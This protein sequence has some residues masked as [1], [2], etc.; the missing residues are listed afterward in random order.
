M[1]DVA[2]LMKVIFDIKKV[3]KLYTNC[4]DENEIAYLAESEFLIKLINDKLCT[5][6]D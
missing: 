6:P 2:E 3:L 5:T 1:N 4:N